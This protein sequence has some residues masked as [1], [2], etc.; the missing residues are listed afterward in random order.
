MFG[1]WLP[2][3][4]DEQGGRFVVSFPGVREVFETWPRAHAY[5]LRELQ[6]LAMDGESEEIWKAWD[7]VR[8]WKH[9]I[10]QDTYEITVGDPPGTYRMIRFG[11]EGKA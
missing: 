5:L 9:S 4:S 7:I 1:P 8:N 3:M 2:G 6:Y 10:S 11:H